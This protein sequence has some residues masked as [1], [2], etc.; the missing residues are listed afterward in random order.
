MRVSLS[1]ARVRAREGQPGTREGVRGS[2]WAL[3]ACARVSSSPARVRERVGCGSTE[4][5]C[6]AV[7]LLWA[8]VLSVGLQECQEVLDK[9]VGSG[10]WTSRAKSPRVHTIAGPGQT[11]A[12]TPSY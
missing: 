11:L 2:A 9:S 5:T 6:R 7:Q 12:R 10:R 3:Q 8:R 1:L 4:G